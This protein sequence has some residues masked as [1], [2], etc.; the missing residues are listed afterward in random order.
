MTILQVLYVLEIAKHHNLS[1]AADSLYVSQPALSLQV[2]RLERELGCELFHRE[3][4]GV[5]LTAAGRAFCQDAKTVAKAW[6][7]LQE[8]TKQLSGAVCREIRI[9]IGPRALASGMF[10]L[11]AAFFDHHPET[12]VT[13]LTDMG[14]HVI[15]ALE[16][17]RM[18]LAIDRLP[19]E[20][21]SPKQNNIAAFELLQERQCIL[22]SPRDPRASLPELSFSDLGGSALVS[23]PE[24]SLDDLIMKQ[25]CQTYGVQMAKVQRADNLEAVMALIRAGKGLALGP[26]SFAHR[27]HIAAVPMLP[28]TYVPLYLLCLKQ[29]E[30]NPLVRRLR[31]Y[32]AKNSGVQ[33]VE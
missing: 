16:E 7:Q 21:I 27:Y 33:D 12:E 10:D 4:Q 19:P 17:K 29:N 6:R 2:K 32:L 14:D 11:T 25:A 24:G 18:D 28:V 8:G 1:K 23:G 5:T 20:E 30:Q 9:G 13:Y 3:P 22:L 15:E 26:A 31:D